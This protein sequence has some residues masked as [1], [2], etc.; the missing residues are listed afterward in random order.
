MPAP[1]A[2]E[3]ARP[4]VP[5]PAPVERVTTMAELRPDERPVVSKEA[6]V[7]IESMSNIAD[8]TTPFADRQQPRDIAAQIAFATEELQHEFGEPTQHRRYS[9]V[10]ATV[11]VL[12]VGGSLVLLTRSGGATGAP[13]RD[14]RVQ[15][16][17]P[18]YTGAAAPRTDS[19]HV[20]EAV[21]SGAVQQG[22]TPAAAIQTQPRSSERAV[23]QRQASIPSRE[24][25]AP[26]PASA[27]VAKPPALPSVALGNLNV[28]V[29]AAPDLKIVPPEML[30]DARTRLTNG[31]DLIEQGDYQVARK[32]FRTAMAQVDSVG[33]RYPDS[34]SIRALRHE[35][36]Q[37]DAKAGQACI[38]EN[39]M[40]RRRGETARACQ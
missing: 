35:I 8:P 23:T 18:S 3:V 13:G 29:N 2:R 14:A 38:A 4:I 33:A 5:A 22:G 39:D 30:V 11:L 36:E 31:E 40:R 16:T 10:A 27:P 9:L 21:S 7:V 19:S 20:H 6:I 26:P 17:V 24:K 34:Q 1:A 15:N 12:L 25:A 32:T 37:A 28:A